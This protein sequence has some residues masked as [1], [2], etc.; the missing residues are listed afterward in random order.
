[1][2]DKIATILERHIE[3]QKGAP[4]PLFAYMVDTS[5]IA[6]RDD[7][8]KAI[9]ALH[10]LGRSYKIIG[11][12]EAEGRDFASNCSLLLGFIH[13]PKPALY[14]GQITECVQLICDE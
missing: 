3:V 2:S 9:T 14:S 10:L 11:V 5:I 1:L 7:I 6:D 12:A 8:I 13:C 4:S